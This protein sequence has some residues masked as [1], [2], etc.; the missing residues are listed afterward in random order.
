MPPS[1]GVGGSSSASTSASAFASTSSSSTLPVPK[2]QMDLGD[3]SDPSDWL[4]GGMSFLKDLDASLR[5]EICSDIL[6]A[7]VAIKTCHHVFCSRCIRDYINQPTLPGNPT[8]RPCPN[9]RQPKVYD[10][11]LVPVTHLEVAA[12]A[13]RSAR[14]ELMRSEREMTQ[15][16]RQQEAAA[17]LDQ[18]GGSNSKK[19]KAHPSQSTDNPSAQTGDSSSSRSSPTHTRMAGGE[20]EHAGPRRVTRS[21]TGSRSGP[22]KNLGEEEEE[23]IVLD[24]DSDED[25]TLE[26][27]AADGKA[28][29]RASPVKSNGAAA[30]ERSLQD[31]QPSDIV[32]CPMCSYTF[33][34]AALNRHLDTAGA[35]KGPDHPPPSDR[36]RGLAVKNTGS[37]GGGLGGFFNQKGK[38]GSST[39]DSSMTNGNKSHDSSAAGTK[40]KR[41]QYRLL[42]ERE[43]RKQCSDS[44]LATTG[45]KAQLESRHRHWIDLYNAN[46]D[47]AQRYRRPEGAL[48]RELREWDKERER[49]EARLAKAASAAARG[50]KASAGSAPPTGSG[51]TSGIVGA[52]EEERRRYAALNRDQFRALEEQ[53][54]RSH[55][56]NKEVH[57]EGPASQERR[58]EQQKL[59]EEEEDAEAK[60]QR[61][62]ATEVSLGEGADELMGTEEVSESA[63]SEANGQGGQD[64][65][66]GGAAAVVAAAPADDG[67]GDAGKDFF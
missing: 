51:S 56:A 34:Y 11:E 43:L 46:L 52:S 14:P 55:R 50:A 65:A 27:G 21:A 37:K 6:R 31:V 64:K 29:G 58:E 36:E 44:G 41:P 35:C 15:L 8:D 32:E 23:A 30:S 18:A 12:E 10:S 22:E 9:C 47:A 61:P 20:S 4:G 63:E 16:K 39:G 60:D 48:R 59:K 24:D 54:R 38:S 5:C 17:S 45:S 40:L 3:V 33:T 28:S 19:R 25:W 1:A 66:A 49:E 67:N 62:V 13:W 57:A 53:G 26:N 42:S 2:W 7:P